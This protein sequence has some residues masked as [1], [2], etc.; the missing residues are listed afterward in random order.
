MKKTLRR[1]MSVL[2][3]ALL[4]CACL[5]PC[6]SAA[7]LAGTTP[8]QFNADGKFKICMFNDLQDKANPDKRTLE[9]VGAVLDQEQPDLVVIAGDTIND[10]Y[11]GATAEDI[12]NTYK[13]LF[14]PIVERDIPFLMTFGN[15]DHDKIGTLSLEG[16]MDV[17]K[18]MSSCIVPDDG[19]DPGTYNV[20]VLNSAGTAYALNVYMMDTGNKNEEVGGYRGVLPEQV[21]WYKAKSDELK[22]ING[23]EVVPSFVFQHIPV[24]EIYQFLER[25]EDYDNAFINLDEFRW[26]KFKEDMTLLPGDNFCLE[27]PCS[28]KQ[29]V[30]TGQYEAWLEKGDIIGAYFGHD[31][32]NNFVGITNEGIQMGYNAG[33]GFAT[34]GNGGKRSARIFVIDEN[35]PADYET[36]NVNY[37][38]V[39]GSETAFVF[40][41]LVSLNTVNVVLRMIYKVFGPLFEVL[42]D[43]VETIAAA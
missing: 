4:V 5:A 21:E 8:L 29:T 41:D 23:G 9:L 43:A 28:E 22:A 34:Y 37:D 40:M 38:Q 6:A 30:T 3:T 39:T 42:M 7:D 18:S 1:F 17:C 24:K 26:Y 11:A 20:P 12:A 32:I 27:A 31:H 33:G 35:A 19:C 15:H 14:A 36:Y 10:A 13:N 2:L 25:T 16:Q